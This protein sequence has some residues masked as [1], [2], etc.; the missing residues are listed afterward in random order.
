MKIKALCAI[1]LIAATLLSTV[2][3]AQV[4]PH[5]SEYY[6]YPHYINPATT[7]LIEA[8]YRVSGIYRNQWSNVSTPFS[9]AALTADFVTGRKMNYGVN[10]LNQS[11]GNGGY[12][13]L[14]GY[15]S[16]A[17]TG[18]RFGEEG[19]KQINLA[20]QIGFINRRIDPSKF[21]LGDQWNPI[22]GYSAINP[23]ADVFKTT[24]TTVLDM[25][26]GALY[27]DGNPEKITN[28]YIGAAAFH[29][30]KP[31]DPFSESA[32]SP[33]PM[34]FVVH[35][36]VNTI[37]SEIVT[38]VP[39]FLYMKQ[40]TAYEAMLGDY[41]QVTA[42]EE[43]DFLFGANYRYQD[44]IAP[45]VGITNNGL[46]FAANYDINISPLGRL[47]HGASSL[48]FTLSYMVKNP[49]KFSLKCPRL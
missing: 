33:I 45:F 10:V 37:L 25:G 9:T 22:T 36:G 35:G 29:I 49:E 2:A 40:G 46:T 18:L 14:N 15:A 16:L 32:K 27:Y 44:A 43:T 24:S 17:Y 5:F 23:T 3:E 21:Q 48:E 47:A 12:N 30:N 39:N 38:M 42:S 26:A 34:R 19:Y 41:F 13:L 7:G 1:G 8:D 4:D 31:N 6:I 11:A 28:F 20:L